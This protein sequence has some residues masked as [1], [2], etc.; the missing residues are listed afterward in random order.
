MP[1][2]YAI[3]AKERIR[4]GLPKYIDVLAEASQRGI[5]EQDT[6]SI[7]RDMFVELLGYDRFKDITAEYA[8]RGHWVDWAIK[9]DDE[10]AF[11][12]EVKRL[13]SRLRDKD[14]F[15]VIAYSAQHGLDWGILTTGDIW[16]CHRI[17]NGKETE[18]FFDIRLLDSNQSVEDKADKL[19]LLSKEAAKRGML[20][21]QWCRAECLRPELI[22]KFLLSEE[23]LKAL[24]RQIHRENPGRRVEYEE[25]REALAR[26]VIRGNLF[27]IINEEAGSRTGRKRRPGKPRSV[28]SGS[29]NRAAGPIQ[30]PTPSTRNAS[31]PQKPGSP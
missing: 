24:R 16:Q 9:Y 12:I 2:K 1:P 21:E 4:K 22:A 19:F 6:S 14:L 17:S 20:E 11:F 25:L 30:G 7:V 23:V 18:E 3:K 28:Q 10:I 29:A 15:Q 5:G 31:Q 13:G 27:D 8:V 26:G